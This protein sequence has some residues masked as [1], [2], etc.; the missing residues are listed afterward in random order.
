MSSK[1]SKFSNVSGIHRTPVKRE[2]GVQRGINAKDF[3]L[4]EFYT[5]FT[6]RWFKRTSRTE[7]KIHGAKAV[8][9]WL[10]P[11]LKLGMGAGFCPFS[12]LLNIGRYDELLGAIGLYIAA[13]GV[14]QLLDL[15]RKHSEGIS[16]EAATLAVDLIS[17]PL[18]LILSRVRS[19]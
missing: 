13:D 2:H 3:I 14:Y 7:L 17:Y 4:D 12:I 11:S 5:E 1:T 9:N 8:P 19:R 6:P 15:M 10:L 16:R 18:Y